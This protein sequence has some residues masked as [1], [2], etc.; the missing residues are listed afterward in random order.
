MGNSQLLLAW[1]SG[2][3][4]GREG[5]ELKPWNLQNKKW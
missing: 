3:N 1:S 2:D 4:G 5:W